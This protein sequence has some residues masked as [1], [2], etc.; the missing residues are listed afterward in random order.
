MQRLKLV[1]H[2]VTDV[3][4]SREHNEDS[5]GWDADIGLVLLADGMGGHNAGE[6]ASEL[7]VTT[8]RE[9]L[10]DV[11]I[12]ELVEA[13]VI[14]F[15][16][17][18]REAVVY[19]NEEIHLQANSRLE[20]AGMGTTLVLTL[21]H[22]SKITFAHV[23]DSRIYRFRNAEVEQIT[24]DHSL[25]Q[26]MVDNGYLSEEEAL[27]STNRNL[28]TRALGISPEVEVDVETHELEKEDIYLLCSDGLSDLLNEEDMQASLIQH[29]QDIAQAAH[30]MVELAN[31]RG[32][33][34]NISV[35]LVGFTE[36]FS[37][38]HGINPGDSQELRANDD[39]GIEETT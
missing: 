35:I 6:I 34:D 32:G 10:H 36:A 4:M 18:V 30:S 22:D 17:A 33:T 39:P 12:P 21:F 29:R 24:S 23:G 5:I 16:D 38:E 28:I 27:L 8:I 13:N 3:G 25:V 19:A 1:I 11:L 2:G 9:A 26:E 7:A 31:S 15:A 14:N 20:C 37:D